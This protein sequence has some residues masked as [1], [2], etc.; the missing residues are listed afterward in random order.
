M[1]EAL[2]L[3]FRLGNLDLDL[4]FETTALYTGTNDGLYHIT[5]DGGSAHDGF[6]L[7]FAGEGAGGFK[8]SPDQGGS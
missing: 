5:L 3:P 2:K 4:V 8:T 1:F 6:F 7:W